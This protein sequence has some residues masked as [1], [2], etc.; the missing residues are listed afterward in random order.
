MSI[1]AAPWPAIEAAAAPTTIWE[2][3]NSA[4]VAEQ[5]DT[6][7]LTISL[8][9]DQAVYSDMRVRVGVGG[10]RDSGG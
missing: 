4:A 5:V 9:S 2:K 6:T 3:D 10:E 1:T 8:T 7:R